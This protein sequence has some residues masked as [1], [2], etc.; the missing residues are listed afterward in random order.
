MLGLIDKY[1]T[2]ENILHVQWALPLTFSPL[3]NAPVFI[4]L[5]SLHSL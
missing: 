5:C 1:T 4:I 2:E 3:D